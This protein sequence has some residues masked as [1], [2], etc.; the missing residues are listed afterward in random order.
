MP[1]QAHQSLLLWG[2]RRMAADGFLIAGFDG[3]A[4]QGG[5]L[6]ELPAPVSVHG[7][8]ADAIGVHQANGMIA[9][10]EAKTASDI[11]NAHTRKQLRVLGFARA[12]GSPCHLYIAVPRSGAYALDR[13]LIDTGL[14]GSKHVRRLHVPDILLTTAA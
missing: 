8:R 13:V 7:V 10:A 5:G 14:I 2:V 3:H 1:S 9:F 12:Q 4:D 11:D 6:N